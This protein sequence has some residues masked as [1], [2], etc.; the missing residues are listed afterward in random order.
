MTD[1]DKDC[2]TCNKRKQGWKECGGKVFYSFSDI[3]FCWYQ[4]VWLISN[5]LILGEDKWPEDP[6]GGTVDMPLKR[7]RVGHEAYYCKP[8]EILAETMTR[9]NKCGSDGTTLIEEIHSGLTDM[10]LLS[11]V[12]KSALFYVSG[13]AR[14]EMPYKAW[15]RQQRY[16]NKEIKDGS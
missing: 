13:W 7:R 10:E 6:L 14:K 5:L 1:N 11:S 4:M 12:A 16:R 9:L 15:G 2:K 8:R 3:Q